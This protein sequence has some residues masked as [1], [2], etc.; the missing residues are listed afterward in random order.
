MAETGPMHRSFRIYPSV[1]DDITTMLGLE[2]ELLKTAS[3]WNGLEFEIIAT[4]FDEGAVLGVVHAYGQTFF[5]NTAEQAVDDALW[6]AG[7][8]LDNIRT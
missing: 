3:E 4:C 6:V 1:L 5:L 7:D 8:E 2:S